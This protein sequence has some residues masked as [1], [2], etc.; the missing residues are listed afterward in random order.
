MKKI[1]Y[2]FF[3]LSFAA[4]SAQKNPSIK[5]AVANDVVGTVDMFNA[6]KSIVQSSNVYKTQAAL[7]QNL[8][9]YSYIADQ[10]ITEFKI[11]NG[12]QGLDKIALSQLNEQYNIAQD[13]PVFIEGYEFTNTKTMV[14]GD[15]LIKT[16]VKDYNGKKSL[17]ITTK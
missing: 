13:T 8:K 17:F 10:G 3:L 2:S 9:K 11:K 4:L 5:F 6:R 16:E 12:F 14:Y 1:L 15:I 7:P